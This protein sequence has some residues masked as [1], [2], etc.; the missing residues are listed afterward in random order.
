MASFPCTSDGRMKDLSP[1][2]IA[3]ELTA[4]HHGHLAN[5]PI[6]H[7]MFP[8]RYDYWDLIHHCGQ[9]EVT[10]LCNALPLIHDPQLI[11]EAER[12]AWAEQIEYHAPHMHWN[13]YKSDAPAV[14]ESREDPDRVLVLQNPD[15]FSSKFLFETGMADLRHNQVLEQFKAAKEGQEL[16]NLHSF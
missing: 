10:R 2:D 6:L 4:V 7:A 1:T 12:G 15:V 16:N 13:W 5:L 3:G 8:G 14:Q 11:S 9:A